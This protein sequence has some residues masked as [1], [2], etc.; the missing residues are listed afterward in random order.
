M[1][2][3]I[4][5][6]PHGGPTSMDSTWVMKSGGVLMAE[7]K[8]GSEPTV[9]S[10]NTPLPSKVKRLTASCGLLARAGSSTRSKN[11]T[12]FSFMPSSTEVTEHEVS[13]ARPITTGLDSQMVIGGV[14]SKS[15]TSRV[16]PSTVS[17]MLTP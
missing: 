5:L 14:A 4:G 15:V 13:M 17:S 10:R 9:G 8:S 2:W 6:P 11:S 12:A 3:K 1:F 16:S 7:A